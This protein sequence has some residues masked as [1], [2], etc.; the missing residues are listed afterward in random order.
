LT[1]GLNLK[2]KLSTLLTSL[3]VALHL[4]SNN[5]MTTSIAREFIMATVP[6]DCPTVSI[7]RDPADLPPELFEMILD[8]ALHNESDAQRL[9]HLALFNRRWHISL[10][11]QIYKQWTYNGARQNFMTM[12]RFVRTIRKHAYIAAMVH[13]LNVGNWGF[14]PG[15][16][17]GCRSRPIQLPPDDIGWIRIAIRDTGLSELENHVLTSLSDGD[18]RPLMAILLASLPNLSTLYAHVPHSDPFL[19][20]VLKK[21]LQGQTSSPLSEL[22]EL[23]LFAE[24]PVLCGGIRGSKDDR[25]FPYEDMRD[26]PANFRLDYLWPVFYLPKVQTLLLYYLDPNKAAEYLSQHDAKSHVENLYL[27]GHLSFTTRDLQALI[28]RPEKLRRL[29]FYNGEGYGHNKLSRSDMWASLRQHSLSLETIDIYFIDPVMTLGHFGPLN[30]FTNLKDL[31]INTDVVLS[32]YIDS[33]IPAFRLQETLPESVQALTLYGQ[34]T[35]HSSVDIPRQLQELIG[36]GF[37]SLKSL[38]LERAWYELGWEDHLC[39]DHHGGESYQ[40]LKRLFNKRG[41]D[42]WRKG[43]DE[44]SMGGVQKKLWPE[45]IHMQRDGQ[46][47]RR[48]AQLCPQSLADT[49]E[50]LIGKDTG[51]YYVLLFSGQSK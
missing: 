24:I 17:A 6:V 42:L 10:Q 28:S 26:C 36:S 45:T 37:S 34:Q 50:V 3:V 41:V 44:L 29:S 1:Y 39:F 8:L 33:P 23:Y 48:A 25:R 47:R 35:Y 20:A 30:T 31:R 11:Y 7:M 19:G 21:T 51:D 9:C 2:S 40:T 38:G 5:R 15:A 22:K 13:S 16:I 4:A 12:L 32:R 14:Y 27:V 49:D 43:T 46:V 18:R